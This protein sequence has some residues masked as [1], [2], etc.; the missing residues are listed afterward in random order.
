[1]F[2]HTRAISKGD[3]IC[4]PMNKPQIKLRLLQDLFNRIKTTKKEQP[5]NTI[6]LL[7]HG[8]PLFSYLTY[9]GIM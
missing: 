7:I 3:L 9:L 8:K 5:Q 4:A 2:F 1:M 6:F